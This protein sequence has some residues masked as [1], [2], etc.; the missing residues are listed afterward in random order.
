MPSGLMSF[1]NRLIIQI[2]LTPQGKNK[3][4]CY[5]KQYVITQLPT[6]ANVIGLPV[7]IDSFA[8]RVTASVFVP[9]T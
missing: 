1:N 8:A 4:A 9:S 3:S 2:K 5:I 6:Y 7:S